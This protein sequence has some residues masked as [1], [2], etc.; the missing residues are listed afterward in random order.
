LGKEWGAKEREGRDRLR[1]DGERSQ[2]RHYI[3][4]RSQRFGGKG[5]RGKREG[6]GAIQRR[7]KDLGE[8][9]D[10]PPDNLVRSLSARLVRKGKGTK[11]IKE[12]GRARGNDVMR[13]SY[14]RMRALAGDE[15]AQREESRRELMVGDVSLFH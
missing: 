7:R 11:P 8:V 15:K 6:K 12:G 5:N 2:D 3:K 9:R 10:P 14:Y 1:K 13:R 4:L